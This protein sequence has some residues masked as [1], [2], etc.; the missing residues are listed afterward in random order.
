MKNPNFFLVGAPKCGTTAL[1]QYLN[2]HPNIYMSDPKEP[3]FFSEEFHL[4]N[5][6]T[7]EQ[8]LKLF[9]NTEK[10]HHIIGEA[11]THYLCSAQAIP[12]IYD[13]NP[14]AKIVA[15]LRNPV[16]LVY[17]YHS[18]LLYNMGDE[19]IADFEQ[20]WALQQSRRQGR[21]I[22][23]LSRNPATLQYSSIGSLG[24]QV[25]KLL[26]TFPANQVQIIFFEDFKSSTLQIYKHV[27]KFLELDYDGRTDFPKVNANKTHRFKALGSFTEKPP[28]ALLNLAAP[29][30]SVLGL[31]SLGVMSSLRQ[32]N[33]QSS[34][35][36]PLKAEFRSI[37]IDEFCP[38]IQ[39][40]SGLVNRDLSHWMVATK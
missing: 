15:M 17:S 4:P 3:H 22:P 5:F 11:S 30:K 33:A 13:Y 10:Q 27:L 40:L 8:Y 12:K 20:A 18:Q 23:R 24:T 21:N 2:T 35:R 34:E 25:E 6:T 26:A 19:D 39:K 7:W 1:A 32:T 28:Q 36:S 38:E 14:D 31:K 9:E 37:L 16:D 29:V